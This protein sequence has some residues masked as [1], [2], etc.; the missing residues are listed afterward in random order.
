MTSRIL[1]S[2]YWNPAIVAFTETPKRLGVKTGIYRKI[3]H[4]M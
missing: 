1:M 3:A 2:P 4:L